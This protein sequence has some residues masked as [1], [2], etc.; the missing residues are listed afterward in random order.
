MNSEE[1]SNVAVEDAPAQSGIFGLAC[2]TAPP[3]DRSERA[4]L[5]DCQRKLVPKLL[6]SFIDGKNVPAKFLKEIAGM[7]S[8]C[9]PSTSVGNA[10]GGGL[11]MWKD[12]S[13]VR[14]C[15]ENVDIGIKFLYP[16]NTESERLE[17]L[18][19]ELGVDEDEMLEAFKRLPVASKK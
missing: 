18:A 1:E 9:F 13:A 6:R 16:D 12:G 17:L 19:A 3:V 4:K 8:S 11:R 7:K 10:R 14:A 15:Q 5:Q 2:G